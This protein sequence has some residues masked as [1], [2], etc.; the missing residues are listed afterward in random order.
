VVDVRVAVDHGKV[1]IDYR[2]LHASWP[3]QGAGLPLDCG[4]NNANL[5]VA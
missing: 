3:A 2:D 4:R 5:P 1:A